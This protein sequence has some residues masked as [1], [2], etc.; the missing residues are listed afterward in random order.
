MEIRQFVILQDCVVDVDT[1]LRSKKLQ[2]TWIQRTCDV[3]ILEDW[4]K[5]NEYYF[6]KT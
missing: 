4:F 1:I 2:G 5:L 6:M 3:P